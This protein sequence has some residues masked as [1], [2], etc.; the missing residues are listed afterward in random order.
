[1][2]NL[3]EYATEHLLH[4]IDD[5]NG[6]PLVYWRE[7]VNT[8]EGYMLV[9]PDGERLHTYMYPPNIYEYQR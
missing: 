7:T 4:R 1:M 3:D 9:W 5:D 8:G 2:L 6:N